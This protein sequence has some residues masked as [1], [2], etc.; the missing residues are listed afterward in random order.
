MAALIGALRVSLSADTAAFQSGMRKAEAQAKTSAS[1]IQKSLGLVRAGFTGLASGLSVGLVIQG[2]KASLD[3]AGSLKEVAQQLGVTT[4]ELQVF[5]YAVQQN[6]GTAEQADQA[7]GKFSLSISKARSESKPAIAAFKA[8]GVE[9]SD[10]QSKTKTDILGQ[11]A[12]KMKATGGASANAAAGV[13]IFGKGFQKIVP[14]LDL[15]SKG[16]NELTAAA[17]DLGIILDDHL[18]DQA[19]EAAD[20]VDALQ[21]VL[22]AQIAGAVAE[23]ADSILALADSLVY[24]VDKIAA[25]IRGWNDFKNA[26]DAQAFDL[27]SNNPFLSPGKRREGAERA[28]RARGRISD[29]GVGWNVA[30]PTVTISLPPPK[31]QGSSAP[32]GSPTPFLG[33]G[34]GGRKRSARAPRDTSLRDAFQF[35]D[36][37]RRLDMDIL[38][39]KQDLAHDYVERTALS[40]QMLDLEK[41]AFEAEL[42]YQ[43]AAKEI[44]QAQADAKALK[45]SEVDHLRR[46]AVLEDEEEQRRRDYNALDDKDFD[47]KMDLLEKQANLAETADERR[48]VELKILDLAYEEERR[49]LNR[50]ITESK[51]WAEIEAARREL[52]DLSKRQSLDRQSVVQN[53]RGPM[54]DYLSTIQSA[55]KLNEAFEQLQ[56]QGFEGLIDA[57][58][59]LSGGFDNAKEALLNTL[60]D[61]FLGL[62][63][64]E[65]Q[66]ALGSALGSIG[67]AGFASGGFTGNI[68]RTKIAG[69]VH[70]EEGVLNPRGLA[71]LGV[72]NL[73]ALNRGMPLTAVSNDNHSGGRAV[74]QNFSFPN[75]DFDSFRRNERQAGRIARRR[76]GA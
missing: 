64:L 43:V 55:D 67:F 4:R 11:I 44:T 6:G 33:G 31:R 3:Y 22:K 20:K 41:Q 7:L 74:V 45:F 66:K 52:L 42:R 10:L 19:D 69:F 58:L 39:A 61:F 47:L 13:A 12:D 68:G 62:A 63:R 15:G 60:K 46:M 24:L 25:A 48:R 54:E 72:P 40:I 17:E 18:I 32:S 50:I 9:L 70:G 30:G 75:S 53:T 21:T 28:A 65:L 37:Q 2:I 38:R 36:E 34:G 23:N 57:A 76:I 1:S 14:V 35:E 8:M 51:D 27:A 29:S 16:F 26:L 49:R 59:A 5:R 56:V 71:T 73:N